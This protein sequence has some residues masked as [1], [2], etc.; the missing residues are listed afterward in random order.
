MTQ[1]DDP[2]SQLTWELSLAYEAL[3]AVY[4]M[5]Q[6]LGKL[7]TEEAIW[8]SLRDAVARVIPVRCG[9][10]L[11][12]TP[13]GWEA[14]AEW[15]ECE[16]LTDV[17]A[18]VA[19]L[20]V[21]CAGRNS[22][23][24]NDAH[25]LA[26]MSATAGSYGLLAVP[27]QDRQRFLAWMML[28]DGTQ[29]DGPRPLT[30]ADQK[31]AVTLAQQVGYAVMSRRLAVEE[32]RLARLDR[33]LEIAREIQQSLLT[34]EPVNLPGWEIAL[35]SHPAYEVSGDFCGYERA[36]TG[37]AGVLMTDVMGKGVPAALFAA[38]TR[39]VL[40]ALGA[41]QDPE[42]LVQRLSRVL[43][44]DLIRSDSFVAL[45]YVSLMPGLGT[46]NLLNGGN[47]PVLIRR[48]S[49]RGEVHESSGPPLGWPGRQARVEPLELAI[50]EVLLMYSDGI[51]DQPNPDGEAFGEARLMASLEA[52]EDVGDLI[53]GIFADV[54]RHQG[55]RPALDDM[56]LAILRRIPT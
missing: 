24:I 8:V 13:V 21:A 19:E 16:P 6:R 51:I 42:M 32:V 15:G 25:L 20:D 41:P 11:V 7:A 28:I 5:S 18:L 55:S 30:T 31:L 14:V 36:G 12:E 40:L 34:P 33:E 52:Y 35:E 10:I 43:L 48:S 3:S 50:G 2:V 38:M 56:T 9:R 29:A 44:P 54:R 45:T 37:G 46:V 4:A 39:T 26:G 17:G 47:P 1:P 27:V 53:A 49:G 23:R 22:V